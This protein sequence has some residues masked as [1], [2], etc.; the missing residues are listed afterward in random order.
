[1][2]DTTSITPP[3]TVFLVRHGETDWNRNGKYQGSSDVP[4]N[5]LGMQQAAQ[6]AVYLKTHELAPTGDAII[7]SPLSRAFAT[8]RAIGDALGIDEILTDA[9]LQERSYGKAEGLTLVQRE[10]RWPDGNWPGLED[11]DHVAERAMRALDLVGKRF[12]GRRVFVVCH[13]G[14]INSILA[15]LSDGA[16]GT[17]KT[18]IINTSISTLTDDGNGWEIGEINQIPHLSVESVHIR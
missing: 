6:L 2:N 1:M 4:L 17:G 5:A 12:A 10:A 15:V 13:G 14:L 11:W 8:A 18:T 9:D 16:I 7:S 3:T